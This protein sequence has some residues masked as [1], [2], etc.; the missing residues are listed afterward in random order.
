[1]E[2][3]PRCEGARSLYADNGEPCKRCDGYGQVVQSPTCFCCYGSLISAPGHDEPWCYGCRYNVPLNCKECEQAEG[4]LC[5]LHAG[6]LPEA[7]YDTD[8]QTWEKRI[9]AKC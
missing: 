3:C 9:R 8:A 5:D 1:M 6:E 4:P 2:V 7:D